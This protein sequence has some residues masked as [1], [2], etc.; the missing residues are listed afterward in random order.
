MYKYVHYSTMYNKQSEINL[1]KCVIIT[2]YYQQYITAQ[3]I[4]Q[5]NVYD[6]EQYMTKNIK[7][8]VQ[9]T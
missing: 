9:Y 4:I 2:L 1:D 7:V 6:N 3:I 8:Q 5:K